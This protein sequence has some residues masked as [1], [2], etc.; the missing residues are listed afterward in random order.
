MQVIPFCFFR[1][2]DFIFKERLDFDVEIA[3]RVCRQSGYNRHALALA[4]RHGKH[5]WYLRMQVED[6][7]GHKE[8]LDYIANL[9]FAQAEENLRLY[10]S[11]LLRSLPDETTELLKLLCTD[12][13]PKNAPIVQVRKF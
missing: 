9:E 8:A 7:G 5:S 12:Y 13:K 2:D 4:E 11:A 10:G 3:I 6:E 1:L